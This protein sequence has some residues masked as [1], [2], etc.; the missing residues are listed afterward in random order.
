MVRDAAGYL[1]LVGS[2]TTAAGDQNALIY[3]LTRT[4]D[5]LWEET[6]GGPGNELI[7]DVKV[8]KF[9]EVFFCGKTGSYLPHP[10]HRQSERKADYYVGMI[11]EDGH[12]TWTRTVGGSGQDIA[13]ACSITRFDG[14]AVTGMSW[15]FD[16]DAEGHDLLQNNQWL[17]VYSRDGRMLRQRMFG[18]NRNDWG[19]GICTTNEGGYLLGGITNSPDLDFAEERHNGDAWLTLLDFAGNLQWTRLL[20]NPLEDAIHDVAANRYGLYAAA[21]SQ[22]TDNAGKQFWLV[23]LDGKGRPVAEIVTGGNGNEE[24]IDVEFLADGGMVAVGYSSYEDLTADGIKGGDDIWVIRT[25]AAGDIIWKR[26]FGGPDDE[27]GVAVLEYEPGVIFILADKENHF[28]TERTSNGRD[29]WL[30]RIEERPCRRINMEVETDIFNYREVAGT[31]IRFTNRTELV[32]QWV[33]DFGDGTTSTQQSPIKTYKQPGVYKVK[34]TA[35]LNETCRTNYYYP[36]PII[37]TP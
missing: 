27:R 30:I 23:K 10:D 8:N 6:W 17:Q 4:G 18:G 32:D 34:V 24:L 26:S 13:Y 9:G 36:Q 11:T 29:F 31:P 3:K 16:H 33:W 2:R 21:G 1:Y 28:N 15:S 14:V 35:I 20:R 22:V 12:L 25:N 7:Y 37:I 5:L 19:T